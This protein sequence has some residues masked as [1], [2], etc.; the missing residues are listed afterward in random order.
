M[1]LLFGLFLFEVMNQQVWVW[2]LIGLEGQTL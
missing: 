1:D 2:E